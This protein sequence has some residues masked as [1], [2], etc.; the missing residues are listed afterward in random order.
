MLSTLALPLIAL[1]G[2]SPRTVTGRKKRSLK[3]SPTTSAA[4][5]GAEAHD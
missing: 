3:V 4:G 1:P 2:I 5:K